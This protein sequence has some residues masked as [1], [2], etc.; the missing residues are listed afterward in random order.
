MSDCSKHK[1]EV[2]RLIE[3]FGLAIILKIAKDWSIYV[4]EKDL[5][6]MTEVEQNKK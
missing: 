1:K 6:Q 3:L 4:R 2:D 5:F